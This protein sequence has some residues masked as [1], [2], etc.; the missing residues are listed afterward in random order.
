MP[1][2]RR[3][4]VAVVTAW[5]LA[6]CSATGPGA[7]PSATGNAA[8]SAST[9]A[10]PPATPLPTV[11]PTRFDG[12]VTLAAG[13]WL[14][15]RCTGIGSPTILL[16]GGGTEGNIGGWRDIFPNTLAAHTTVC[17]YSRRGGE[18]S[19]APPDPLTW[20]SMLGD[21]DQLLETVRTE[22]GI[23]GP[24]VFVGWSFGGE[25]ALGEAVAHRESTVGLVILDTDFPRDFMTQCR[26]AGRSQADC[27]G[28]FDSDRV[29]K[30]IEVGLV[31]S[32][33]PLPGVP[34][35]LV[36]AMR[37]SPD[38]AVEPGATGVSYGLAGQ[39][40]TAPDCDTLMRRI[41]DTG[42]ADW[43]TIG[44]VTQSRVDADHDGLIGTAGPQ[45]A[46]LIIRLISARS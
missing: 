32:I 1:R 12:R 16:E 35:L 42:L 33:R 45:I 40:I 6:A 4:A 15:A 38:C 19:S 27:Q 14:Q 28:E 9:A 24:Y 29:A 17:R 22:A 46:E 23:D 7:A 43:S 30:Q 25:V 37:P 21:A 5:T 31:K 8:P 2:M 41:A 11:P 39:E 36:S 18:G 13:G 44:S 26:A 20:A 34:I 3:A 10:T